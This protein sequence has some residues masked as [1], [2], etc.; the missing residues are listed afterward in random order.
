MSAYPEHLQIHVD[1]GRVDERDFRAAAVYV[2][3][4]LRTLAGEQRATAELSV[5]D[6]VWLA[7]AGTLAAFRD[8]HTCVD[9]AEHP[10]WEADLRKCPVLVAEPHTIN[11]ARRQPF[12]LDL[13]RLYVHRSW[14]EECFVAEKIRTRPADKLQ[15]ITGGPGTGK[16]TIVAN[17]LVE[18]LSQA[19]DEPV[20]IALA[21]PTGKAAK[22][23][24]E[25]MD[26]AL[27]KA[28]APQHVRDGV[29]A[30]P[31]TT[32]HSLLGANPN[33][34]DNR[35]TYHAGNK[36]KHNIV[37]V[38]E[39]SM[40]SL[41]MMY[42]LLVALEDEAELILVGDPDQLAS[43]EA[44]TVLA[45]I[46]AG[47]PDSRITR[48]TTQHRFKDSPNIVAA[49]SAIRDGNVAATLAA[50]TAGGADVRWIDPID[51]P[52]LATE[53]LDSVVE[54]AEHVIQLAKG[55]QLVDALTIK[56]ELQVLCAH[57]KGKMGVAGWNRIVEE[58]LGLNASNQW[59]VGRP[60][61][62][63]ENDRTTGLFN[64]DV[65]VVGSDDT[66]RVSCFSTDPAKPTIPV[67]RLPNVETVHALTIHK[68]QGSEYDH[69]VV[70]LPDRESRILTREL[71]YTGVTRAK[72]RLTIIGSTDAL[73]A[74]VGKPIRRATG[75]AGR[76]S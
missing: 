34:V 28:N 50:V 11:A 45:D 71:L 43:V 49:A 25:A 10:G 26:A 8:Q 48:L 7:V 42:H 19:Q 27:T 46:V 39:T 37:I 24:T 74:A 69:V 57:R 53:V 76:L 38:D 59:Y 20:F 58:R 62:V 32:I 22:R 17:Q 61:I 4:A 14:E 41:S 66:H 68:S 12:I 23:M 31:A 56:S 3:L 1:E 63:T 36:L 16:T 54:H 2:D 65:A 67:T 40:L 29:L 21:A 72:Q 33:R 52:D 60:I 6:N 47:S 9:L 51:A 15:V 35:F 75:L 30:A 55:G 64:G 5:T 44:G 73:Q 18:R 13:G 70:V